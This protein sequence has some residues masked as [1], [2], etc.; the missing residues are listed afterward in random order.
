M[1]F[2]F[3]PLIE[4]VD[5]IDAGLLVGHGVA[6]DAAEQRAGRLD[7]CRLLGEARYDPDLDPSDFD[8]PR[9]PSQPNPYFP[10]TVGSRWLYRG[11]A[12]A[13]SVEV[14]DETK[15]IEGITCAVVRDQV[16]T[17]GL[18]TEKTDD[19]YAAAKDGTVWYFG[20]EV[21][22]Y[23]SFAGDHPRRPELVSIDGSFKA[24][25]DGDKPGVI[26]EGSPEK[27]D[28]YLEEFSL[29]NAEDLALILATDYAFGK[30]PDLDKAVPKSLA[31]R[32]CGGGDCVVTKNT[33]LLEP[34]LVERK[35]Y[36]P[37]VGLFLETNPD[38]GEVLQLVGCNVDSRCPPLP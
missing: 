17:D 3:P 19:W 26:F 12:E 6:D 8:D 10:L 4:A 5:A 13:D 9:H 30:H 25:R 14:V 7:A 29:A 24:G 38:T 35:Y 31:D 37:G 1:L 33:S 28:A 18:V 21:K 32:Y 34:G 15:L 20:E 16:T 2:L 36:S 22:T 23:E 27:G 11:G